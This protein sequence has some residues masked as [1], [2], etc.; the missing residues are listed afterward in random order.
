MR[1]TRMTAD[2]IFYTHPMSR[3]RIVCWILEETGAEYDTEIL[4]YET[5]MKAP[6]YLAINPMGQ[7]PA[8]VHGGHV[9]TE[10]AAICAYL[11]DVFSDAGL[12]PRAAGRAEYYQWLFFAAGPLEQ[13]VTNRYLWRR[14]DRA[15]DPDGGLW[16]L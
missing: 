14:A 10:C 12:A 4:D 3:G 8:M 2:L 13:A 5:G 6:A 16:Q 15:T 11:A 7:V 1:D 9:V